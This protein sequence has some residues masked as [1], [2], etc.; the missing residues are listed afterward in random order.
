MC[1]YVCVCERE[2]ER[3]R[4]RESE[5]VGAGNVYTR[6][7]LLLFFCQAEEFQKDVKYSRKIHFPNDQLPIELFFSGQSFFSSESL[8]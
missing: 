7:D 1:G 2:R 6:E 8:F 4:E 5:S 3:E